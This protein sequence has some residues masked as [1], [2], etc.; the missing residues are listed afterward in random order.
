MNATPVIAVLVGPLA[1]HA[2]GGESLLQKAIA[3]EPETRIHVIAVDTSPANLRFRP[4]IVVPDRLTRFLRRLGLEAW[5]R[6]LA[7][8]PAGRLINSIG[9]LDPGRVVWRSLRGDREARR[10][11]E[12]SDLLI[13]ADSTAVMA[14]WHARRRHWVGEARFDPRAR[15]FLAAEH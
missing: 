6:A 3:G 8:S 14:A 1:D 7:G 9:P 2:P 15:E 11:L 4:A 10:L 12:G 13:A 5:V